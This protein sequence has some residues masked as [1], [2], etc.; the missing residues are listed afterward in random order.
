MD[1]DDQYIKWLNSA[2]VVLADCCFFEEDGSE[3]A[4]E[5]FIDYWKLI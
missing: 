3:I 4:E 5:G 2:L 1:H